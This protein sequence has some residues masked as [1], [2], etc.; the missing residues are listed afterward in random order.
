MGIYQVWTM[1][2]CMYGHGHAVM[3]LGMCGRT[4]NG[5]SILWIPPK[6]MLPTCDGDDDDDDDDA[7][8][9]NENT[10]DSI[11]PVY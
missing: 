9:A 7:D 5:R 4:F 8:D 10:H 6:F 1:Y 2:V 3:G 11:L